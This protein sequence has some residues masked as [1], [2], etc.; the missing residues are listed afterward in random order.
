MNQT[1]ASENQQPSKNA[2]ESIQ[3]LNE[4]ANALVMKLRMTCKQPELADDVHNVLEQFRFLLKIHQ[5]AAEDVAESRDLADLESART[6]IAKSSPR[7]G[8]LIDFPAMCYRHNS[9]LGRVAELILGMLMRDSLDL[10]A[11]KIEPMP[12]STNPIDYSA[13]KPEPNTWKLVKRDHAVLLALV[14]GYRYLMEA[15]DTMLADS[16]H[17]RINLIR[18]IRGLE[19]KAAASGTIV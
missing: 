3:E 2:A 19:V 6:L 8:E 4:T 18:R 10:D 13:D 9:G 17:T 15:D 16:G 1:H 12:A 14:R 7:L 5:V 11:F